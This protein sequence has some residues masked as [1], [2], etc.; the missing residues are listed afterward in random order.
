M[1]HTGEDVGE[2]LR[3]LRFEDGRTQAEIAEACGRLAADSAMS[4]QDVSRFERG[5][6]VPGRPARFRLAA[7]YGVDP[8]LLHRAAALSRTKRRRTAEAGK[9]LTVGV[10]IPSFEGT[11]GTE[12]DSVRRRQFLGAAAVGAGAV[13]EPWGRLAHALSGQGRPDGDSV[14]IMARRSADLFDAET[15]KPASQVYGDLLAQV[16]T[17]SLLIDS[18]TNPRPFVALAGETAALAGWVAYDLGDS[19]A[20]AGYYDVA[21]RAARE[22]GEPAVLALVM[23]YESYAATDPRQAAGMLAAAQQYVRGPGAATARAWLSARE[24]EERAT[25]GDRDGALRAIERAHAVFDY[26]NPT[27]EQPWVKFFSQARLD[28]MT[29]ATYG[30][31]GHPELGRVSDA[32]LAALTPDDLKVRAVILGDVATAYV[33][34]GEFERGAEVAREALTVTRQGEATLGRQRLGALAARLPATN[35]VAGQ[36][37]GELV[38]AL[39]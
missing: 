21:R 9:A 7:V 37:R 19:A 17:L 22:S 23:A 31:L 26:A 4:G 12:V 14:S 6:R 35:S 15:Q 29:V 5:V 10:D 25:A 16:N 39:G 20:A 24:A 2:L 36:L 32:A 13:A 33:V 1:P 8:D 11:Y 18:A 38:A 27:G 28:S 3:R 30:R 34:Q